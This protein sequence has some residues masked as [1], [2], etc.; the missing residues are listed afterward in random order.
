[1]SGPVNYKQQW[2]TIRLLSIGGTT[3][4]VQQRYALWAMEERGRNAGYAQLEGF[5]ED[6]H[7]MVPL[8]SLLDNKEEVLQ[9]LDDE[10]F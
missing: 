1:M 5:P 6:R 3:F 10:G 9:E 7:R 8:M 2:K 4:V